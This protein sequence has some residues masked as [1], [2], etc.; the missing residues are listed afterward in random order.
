[1]AIRTSEVSFGVLVLSVLSICLLSLVVVFR[2][3]VEFCLPVPTTVAHLLQTFTSG[4]AV[5]HVVVK[6][7][8]WTGRCWT[9]EPV[10]EPGRWMG[11]LLALWCLST[12]VEAMLGVALNNCPAYPTR[13]I[14]FTPFTIF[15]IEPPPP[16]APGPG[17]TNHRFAMW[18]ITR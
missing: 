11:N 1:M 13:E 4:V 2:Y 5:C 8:V 14:D 16:G 18:S 15:V 6:S 9:V 10:D 12:A 7:S 17:L 3:L